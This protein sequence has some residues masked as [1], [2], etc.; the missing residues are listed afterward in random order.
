MHTLFLESETDLD[1]CDDT[2]YIEA[3]GTVVMVE[4][5]PPSFVILGTQ[6]I[7][8][9][10]KTDEIAVHGLLHKNTRWKQPADRLPHLKGVIAF[11]GT[12]DHI[13]TF[14][15]SGKK[16]P[17]TSIVVAVNDITYLTKKPLSAATTSRTKKLRQKWREHANTQTTHSPTEEST[18]S[19]STSQTLLGK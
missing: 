13:D 19:P 3:S 5:D 2:I 15:P 17:T 1:R 11:R 12:L 8:G 9:G 16:I 18:Q 6:Y 14:V 7:S 4:K 10:D